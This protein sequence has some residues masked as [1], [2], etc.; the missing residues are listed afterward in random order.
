MKWFLYFHWVPY[1][2][3]GG[4]CDGLG[5]CRRGR[6]QEK[7]RGRDTQL[8]RYVGAPQIVPQGLLFGRN[9]EP[10]RDRCR[11]LTDSLISWFTSGAKSIRD[12]M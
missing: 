7:A 6:I 10:V 2:I 12:S 5:T 9:K 8:E 11:L 3:F 4:H 1:S